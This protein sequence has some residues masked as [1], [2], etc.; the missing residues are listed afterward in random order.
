M[1]RCDIIAIGR[2]ACA[3]RLLLSSI[4]DGGSSGR[5][6]ESAGSLYLPI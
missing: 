3:A 5:S 2:L 4:D 6:A 1:Q